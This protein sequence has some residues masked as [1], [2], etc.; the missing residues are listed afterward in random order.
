MLLWRRRLDSAQLNILSNP[1]HANIIIISCMLLCVVLI[2]SQPA[3]RLDFLRFIHWNSRG[4]PIVNTTFFTGTHDTRFASYV[5]L[6][7]EWNVSASQFTPVSL[8]LLLD[9]VLEA[10]N[11]GSGR[12]ARQQKTE[13]MNR[14]EMEARVSNHI[15]SPPIYIQFQCDRWPPL[16]FIPHLTSFRFLDV[17][18]SSQAFLLVT[19]LI[20]KSRVK[21]KCQA[22]IYFP[23]GGGGGGLR[24]MN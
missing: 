23:F 24:G 2:N 1:F 10:E 6:F 19:F 9:S 17:A 3:H 15:S 20:K 22:L 8:D 4:K 16:L 11:T 14:L 13:G 21:E 7:L 18:F 5:R 12:R